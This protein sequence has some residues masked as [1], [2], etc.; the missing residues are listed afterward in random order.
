MESPK[1]NLPSRAKGAR[2]ESRTLI[3]E[4][5]VK[6]RV[7]AHRRE[8]RQQAGWGLGKISTGHYMICLLEDRQGAGRE[9][10]KE[11]WKDSG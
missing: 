4:G 2:A 6:R 8:E 7:S 11:D 3:T 5:V 1:Q 9:V 10:E